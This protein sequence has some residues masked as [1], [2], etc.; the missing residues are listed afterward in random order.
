MCV[1][2]IIPYTLHANYIF[3][4]LLKKSPGHGKILQNKVRQKIEDKEYILLD[5]IY[6]KIRNGKQTILFI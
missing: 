5:S 1:H 4:C 2:F 6:I 3:T